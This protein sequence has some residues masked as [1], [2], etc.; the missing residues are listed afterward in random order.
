MPALTDLS[1][2]SGLPNT[3]VSDP[4]AGSLLLESRRGEVLSADLDQRQVGVRIGRH[5]LPANATS[6]RECDVDRRRAVHNMVVGEDHAIRAVDHAAAHAASS[7]HRDNLGLDLP[8]DGRD[9][10]E[11]VGRLRG[12]RS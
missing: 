7:Q 3:T 10:R 4:T 6:V 1:N 12:T 2:P 11:D 8:H 9:P 5:D